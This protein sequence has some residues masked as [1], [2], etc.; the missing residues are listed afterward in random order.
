MKAIGVPHHYGSPNYF[1]NKYCGSEAIFTNLQSL[2]IQSGLPG[3]VLM[4]PNAI[5]SFN[6]VTQM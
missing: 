3:A 4:S 1:S 5:T 2:I 6:T